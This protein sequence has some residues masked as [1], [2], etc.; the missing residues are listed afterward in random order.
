MYA[1]SDGG[2][3]TIFNCYNH[4]NGTV[5]ID[6]DTQS[7]TYDTDIS[8]QGGILGR[9]VG[10]GTAKGTA[11]VYNCWSKGDNL[12][13]GITSR[14]DDGATLNLMNCY[15][16][17]TDI[18]ISSGSGATLNIENSYYT[19]DWDDTYAYYTIGQ[20]TVP[21]YTDVRWNNDN[22]TLWM[23]HNDGNSNLLGVNFKNEYDL[24]TT[25]QGTKP[26]T[27]GDLLVIFGDAI[28]E[29]SGTYTLGADI[30]IGEDMKDYFPI[31]IEDGKVFD[32][33]NKTITYTGSSD[34]E[35]LFEAVADS[36]FTVQN[37]TFDLYGSDLASRAGCITSNN[38][39]RANKPNPIVNITDN[40]SWTIYNCHSTSSNSKQI[41]NSG[42]G[43]CGSCIG[44]GSATV[45]ITDCTNQ[46]GINDYCGGICGQ[47]ASNYEIVNCSNYGSIVGDYAGGIC[48]AVAYNGTIEY[49]WN[50]GPIGGGSNGGSGG[51]CGLRAGENHTLEI[52]YCYNT[53]TISSKNSGGICGLYAGSI[54]TDTGGSSSNLTI[55]NCYNKASG[56]SNVN[57][58]GGIVGNSAG[59]GGGTV[60]VY[61]CWSKG[62]NLN[63]G[64]IPSKNDS[65]TVVVK[66]CYY[67]GNG[68]ITVATD[69]SNN[70]KTDT[71]WDDTYAYYTIGQGT[72][73][74]YTDVRWYNDRSNSTDI[75]LI[76]ETSSE[77]GDGSGFKTQVTLGTN[78]QGTKPA[79]MG[80][81]LVIF[82][83]AITENSGTYTL[84]ATITIGEDKKGYFPIS[85]E[86]GVTFDGGYTTTNP[87][88]I[89]YTGSSD[90]EGLFIPVSGT[91]SSNK[92]E[93]TIQNIKF[94][95]DGTNGANV[96]DQHGC[97][98]AAS[99]YSS[100][101][102]NYSFDYFSATINNCHTSAT[103][104][105][106]IAGAHSGGIC[107]KA[108]GRENSTGTITNCTNSIPISGSNAGVFAEVILEVV[109]AVV[110]ILEKYQVIKQ[111]EY[112]AGMQE[113]V[114][115]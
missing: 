85:I 102:T 114:N 111:V 93:F 98:L 54:N 6:T 71:D 32:G 30:T 70:K 44:S 33:G 52:S 21:N 27:M 88:T 97:I 109:S 15:S 28:T 25:N 57:G 5:I 112:V 50:E 46:L 73:T 90:W 37:V 92:K 78:N 14:I 96:A 49:C 29:N 89:T 110:I 9:G 99:H 51:I 38:F 106:K 68:D 53:R 36:S 2:V 81:L 67:I 101:T 77:M 75:W 105:A 34:W 3:L 80:D 17:I 65:A 61:N 48:G 24:S 58:Q 4:A 76:G 41:T 62:Q 87:I 47:Y 60:N 10:N 1:G 59:A 31:L 40:C 108:L 18:D 64:I 84:G 66:N 7:T 23:I 13:S 11:N 56:T 55:F 12:S 35:G 20:G 79:T 63:K 19:S 72:V 16:I 45:T 82:G 86:N 104:S 91:S 39:D 94:V 107:G 42:G 22:T 103:N 69:S 83:D 115:L 113:K 74:N 8:Y 100:T 95:L 43:L 26:A